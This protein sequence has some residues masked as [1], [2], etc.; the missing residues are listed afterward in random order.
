MATEIK[1]RSPRKSLPPRP[2]DRDKYFALSKTQRRRYE[3]PHPDHGEWQ[4]IDGCLCRPTEFDDVVDLLDKT[5]GALIHCDVYRP[6]P[7]PLYETRLVDNT[8][9]TIVRR[10]RDDESHLTHINLI[11]NDDDYFD[12]RDPFNGAADMLERQAALFAEAAR[13]VRALK[14]G[15]R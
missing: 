15:G 10:R 13:R 11:V 4:I 2:I 8:P 9:Q 6:D 12:I 1:S 14:G 3:N 5:I 7:H